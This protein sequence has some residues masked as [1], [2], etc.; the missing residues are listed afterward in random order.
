VDNNF[1]C[2]KCKLEF[3]VPRYSFKI[4]K[5]ITSYFISQTGQ[6]IHCPVCLSSQVEVIQQKTDLTTILYGRFS[7]ASDEEKKRILKKRAKEHNKKTE[8]QYHTIDKEFRGKVNE[9]HY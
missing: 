4:I 5:S 7:S 2:T 3:L 9:K 6:S 1:R 8:E